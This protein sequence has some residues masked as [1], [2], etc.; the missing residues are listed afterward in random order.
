MPRSI[1]FLASIFILPVA[2]RA[3]PPVPED[4]FYEVSYVDVRPL[5]SRA[6]VLV[7]FQEYESASND[8]DGFVRFEVYEESGEAGNFSTIEIWRDQAAFDQ[9]SDT[10]RQAL[11]EVIDPFR[12]SNYD[13]RPYQSLNVQVESRPPSPATVNVVA[14]VDVSRDPEVAALIDRMADESRLDEGNVRYDVL[15]HT[16]RP[17][18]FTVIEAWQNL[19]AYQDHVQA[20]HT[21]QYRDELGP[22]LGSPLD[23]RMYNAIEPSFRR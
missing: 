7:A 4:A 1:L 3:Q 23:Q 16:M 15:I 21:R 18:H 11:L 8:E 20:Q 6:A 5:S 10:P 14:H 19:S 22:Y 17:N 12:V 13:Q 2:L 9:R